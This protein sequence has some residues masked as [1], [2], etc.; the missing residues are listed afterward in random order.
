MLEFAIETRNTYLTIG[1]P[2]L[3][4]NGPLNVLNE[5]VLPVEKNPVSK[6]SNW[7]GAARTTAIVVVRAR[8]RISAKGRIENFMAVGL[9]GGSG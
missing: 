2:S 6:R 3:V 1:A 5:A 9:S 4:P 7:G 8:P